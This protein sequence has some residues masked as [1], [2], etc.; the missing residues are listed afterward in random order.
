METELLLDAPTQIPL[1]SLNSP[2]GVRTRAT[3]GGERSALRWNYYSVKNGAYVLCASSDGLRALYHAEVCTDVVGYRTY[4]EPVRL[5]I[6]RRSPTF[7]AHLE[8]TLSD[9]RIVV[10]VFADVLGDG[11]PEKPEIVEQL[12]AHYAASGIGFCVRGRAEFG[13]ETTADAVEAI[14][15]FRRT[16]VTDADIWLVKDT[17]SNRS[18]ARLAEIRDRFKSPALGFAKLSAMMVRRVVAIDLRQELGPTTPVCMLD[19]H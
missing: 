12:R 11:H 15:T 10:S 19:P 2:T 7:A 1:L 16:S 5:K 4:L 17:I 18:N 9:G 13:Q 8:E 3:F 14:Q 6:E